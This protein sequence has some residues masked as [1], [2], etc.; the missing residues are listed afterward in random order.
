MFVFIICNRVLG[1]SLS[2]RFIHW[3]PTS[4]HWN[5]LN[6]QMQCKI[7]R[8]TGQVLF[9]SFWWAMKRIKND[10]NGFLPLQCTFTA[11]HFDCFIIMNI[12]VFFLQH[13]FWI[14]EYY[15]IFHMISMHY[16]FLNEITELK[17][18]HFMKCS[19]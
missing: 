10:L 8:P 1:L 13:F 14:S 11:F 2:L 6:V 7:D 12:L 18:Q 3:S 19:R 15:T 9:Y 17:W 5:T 16:E 4:S